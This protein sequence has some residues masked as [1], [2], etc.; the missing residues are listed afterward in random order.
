MS[1][2]FR[3]LCAVAMTLLATR[4]AAANMVGKPQTYVIRKEDVFVDIARK[5]DLGYN[6]LR[7]ANPTIDPWVPRVGTRII[8][9]TAHILPD[10]PHKGIVI[11]LSEERIY[12]YA[13]DKMVYTFPVGVVKEGLKMPRTPG[14]L[15]GK[16]AHP[17]WVPPP[18]VR[19]ENPDLPRSI[20][21]GPNNPLGDYALY[22]NWPGI[23]L[24]GT[25]K[26]MGVG[27]RVSHGCIRLYPENIKWL[28]HHVKLGI[29]LAVVNQPVKLSWEPD[30]LYMEVNP[31][32]QDADA[33]EDNGQPPALSGNDDFMN[34]AIAMVIKAQKENGPGINWKQVQRIIRARDGI[35]HKITQN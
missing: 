13:S 9:P 12:Y 22:A 30:G 10:A 35:P 2:F 32:L 24:H 23:R 15:V 18:S 21:P 5:Y 26:P 3:L 20:P 7:A 28:F 34:M 16:R 1:L 6:A 11:N 19:K 33:V 17:T 14:R 8:L 4:P 31:R 29:P 27:R 25:N